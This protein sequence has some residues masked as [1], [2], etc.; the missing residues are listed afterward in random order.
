[1]TKAESDA[2][3]AWFEERAGFLLDHEVYRKVPGPLKDGLYVSESAKSGTYVAAYN[4]RLKELLAI[5]GLPAW[6]PGARLPSE[7]EMRAALEHLAPLSK[8][9]SASKKE[10]W[11][12]RSHV[13]RWRADLSVEPTGFFRFEDKLVLLLSWPAEDTTCIDVLDVKDM[14]WMFRTELRSNSELRA[15]VVPSENQ[16]RTRRRTG[17]SCNE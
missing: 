6:A 10:G 17:R 12:V 7:N 16:I 13:R 1:M 11:L 8:Y 2:E 5:H 14:L 15:A 4:R 9:V 3:Q